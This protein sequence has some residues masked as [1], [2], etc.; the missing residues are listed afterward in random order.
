[1]TASARRLQRLELL[2]PD[3]TRA[4][5]FYSQVWGLDQTSSTMT[6]RVDLA[7][8]SGMPGYLSLR[9][10]PVAALG[11]TWFAVDTAPEL[12]GL[13]SR[14]RDHG[15][16]IRVAAQGPGFEVDGPA[17]LHL[18]I[19][20]APVP[21]TVRDVVPADTSRPLCLT[22][23]VVNTPVLDVHVAFLV[24]GLGFR[25]SD[26]TARM[27]FLRCGADHHSL[28]LARGERVS[29]N[30]AA[31]AM[32][33]IDGLMQGAGRLIDHGHAVEWGLGRHGPGNNVFSYFVDP[34]GFAVEYTTEME[35][36]GDDYTGQDAAYW[37][38]FPR[39]P[40]RW[41]VARKP[42]ER[43]TLAF[44]GGGLTSG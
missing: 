35:Q 30:H 40:C 23:V 36:V 29:L 16:D 25:V 27:V 1:M 21:V 14:A 31:Y 42:S 11:R 4:A 44:S 13:A 24:D 7:A 12:D 18:G 17:G 38:A 22:H 26:V 3:L 2:V 41:G 39:R 19:T 28:A 8:A 5:R 33:G 6:D 9:Q 32:H 10:A 20:C 43:L 15:A 37:D 34:D